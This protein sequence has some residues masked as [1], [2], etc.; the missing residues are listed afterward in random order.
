MVEKPDDTVSE[1][2][3]RDD[4]ATTPLDILVPYH[5]AHSFD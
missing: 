2:P 4:P 1:K 3:F 5:P